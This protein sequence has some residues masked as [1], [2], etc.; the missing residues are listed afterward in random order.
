[1]NIFHLTASNQRRLFSSFHLIDRILGGRQVQPLLL[2][3]FCAFVLLFLLPGLA[4]AHPMHAEYV[5]SDP[6]A[7]AMLQKA[8]TT[9]TIHFMEN[10]NPQGSDI[11]VYDVDG[12][13]VS[14]GST[15]VDRADLKSMQVNLQPN[16]SEIYTV[17]WHNVSAVEGHH[18]SG[19]FRFFVNISSM[20]KGMMT[21]SSNGSSNAMPG[22]GSS[23]NNQ[24]GTSNASS[25]VPPWLAGLI[26]IIGLIVGGGATYV[27]TRQATQRVALAATPTPS[28]KTR[29]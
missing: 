14:T 17:N 3:S 22:M 9:I 18:D 12:K 29:V 28:T 10:L 15:Q 1:M 7:N 26:G 19:S 2:G 8:P 23:S 16:K 11:T 24:A 25:G 4:L 6:A 13:Q 21:N 27:F 5:S 20:L